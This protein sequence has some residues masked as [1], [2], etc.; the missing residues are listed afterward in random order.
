MMAGVPN[1]GLKMPPHSPPRPIWFPKLSRSQ[2]GIRF[3]LKSSHT[4]PVEIWM[5]SIGLTTCAMDVPMGV[6]YLPHVA[7]SAVRP[8]PDRSYATPRRGV[9]SW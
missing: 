2:S 1:C 9:M 3:S 4:R 7:L 8:S 5:A 6:T